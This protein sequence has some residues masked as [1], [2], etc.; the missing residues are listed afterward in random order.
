MPHGIVLILRD[1]ARDG[2]EID[3]GPQLIQQQPDVA[4]HFCLAPKVDALVW[5]CR[6]VEKLVWV[7]LSRP[8]NDELQRIVDYQEPAHGNIVAVELG[9]HEIWT[10]RR[11]PMR[12]CRSVCTQGRLQQRLERGAIELWPP[13]ARHPSVLQYA[14]VDI[15]EL[16]H[17]IRHT[18]LVQTTSRVHDDHG[19]AR[20]RVVWD[21]F[22][23]LLVLHLHVSVVRCDDKYSVAVLA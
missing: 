22:V 13:T 1:V 16:R 23:K 2:C 11:R 17:N 5:I 15:D 4:L 7:L 9:H 20:A 10:A 6:Q 8:P 12:L 18:P 21:H 19:H 3:D 14:R